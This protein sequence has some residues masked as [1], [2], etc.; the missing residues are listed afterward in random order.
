MTMQEIYRRE[1]ELLGWSGEM[2][3]KINV[4][5]NDLGISTQMASEYA[6]T[7]VRFAER[8]AAARDLGSRTRTE[9]AEKN[10][11][12]E[13][14]INAS[15]TIVAIL[16]ANPALTNAQRVELNIP[17]RDRK[18]TPR[19]TPDAAPLV[20]VTGTAGTA[21]L[22]DLADAR[23]PSRR[24]RPDGVVGATLLTFVGDVAPTDLAGWSF[25]S[26][27]NKTRDVVVEFPPGTPRGSRVWVTAFLVQRQERDRPGV[28][29]GQ[30]LR[31]GGR[32]AGAGGVRG[33]SRKWE[34]GSRKAEVS[35]GV[36]AA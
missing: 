15:R 36:R 18:P 8:F 22:V 7:Q 27:T 35:R 25:Y 19:P 6:T 11:A 9:V 30:R 13:A 28:A 21:V 23:D 24:R 26:N 20:Q 3:T 2:S 31:R 4:P 33:R 12:K 17:V 29:P 32:G 10:A 34:V 5:G 14:L 16:E 1:A